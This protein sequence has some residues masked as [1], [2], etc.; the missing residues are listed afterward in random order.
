MKL[1]FQTTDTRVFF[2]PNFNADYSIP[3]LEKLGRSPAPDEEVGSPPFLQP[4]LGPHGVGNLCIYP[5][6]PSGSP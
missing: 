1:E 5:N 4:N 6:H 2:L 3:G